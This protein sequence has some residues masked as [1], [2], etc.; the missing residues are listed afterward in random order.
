MAAAS[1]WGRDGRAASL[2]AGASSEVAPSQGCG[3]VPSRPAS[4]G[5]WIEGVQGPCLPILRDVV[6][7]LSEYSGA[8]HEPSYLSRKR[9]PFR[10]VDL[11]RTIIHLLPLFFILPLIAS[12]HPLWFSFKQPQNL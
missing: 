6:L 12:P 7:C 3:Q 4:G 10:E 2:Q 5:A 11:F 8:L 9:F 1:C